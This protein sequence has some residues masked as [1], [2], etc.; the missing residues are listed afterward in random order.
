MRSRKKMASARDCLQS[1]I[2]HGGGKNLGDPSHG[3]VSISAPY[4]QSIGFYPSIFGQ[5][6]LERRGGGPIAYVRRCRSNNVIAHHLGEGIKSTRAFVK[7]DNTT[8][9][10]RLFCFELGKIFR[11]HSAKHGIKLFFSG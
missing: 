1:R 6:G 11:R 3:G 2:R 4:D 7:V 5:R 10:I 9:R 8:G